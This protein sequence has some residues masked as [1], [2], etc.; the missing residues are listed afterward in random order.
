[1]GVPALMIIRVFPRVFVAVLVMMLMPVF[2]L[3]FVMVLVMML[4]PVLL[5]IG[6][7]VIRAPLGMPMMVV[8]VPGV[9]VLRVFDF[10]NGAGTAEAASFVAV[11]LQFPAFQPK[12]LQLRPQ[13]TGIN[14][15][16]HKSPQS[17][18]PGN[19][20]ETVKM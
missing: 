20:R 15:Q 10:H 3:V 17:H 16:I 5:G 13:Q 2:P 11:K 19:P 14:P 6:A 18:I 9:M 1:M 8:A 12:F 4:M 7:V